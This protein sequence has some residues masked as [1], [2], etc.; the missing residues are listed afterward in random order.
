MS[1]KNNIW[2]I[3]ACVGCAVVAVIVGAIVL[4]VAFCSCNEDEPCPEPQTK[5][6]QK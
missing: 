4:M 3:E 5:V 6:R 1:N 2:S